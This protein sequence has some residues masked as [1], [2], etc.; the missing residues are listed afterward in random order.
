MKRKLED[1]KVGNLVYKECYTSMG[2]SS[3][4]KTIVEE[5]DN[6]WDVNTGEKFVI[7]KV[8]DEWYDTRNGSCFSNPNSMFYIESI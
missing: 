7:L 8:D 6:K 5:I 4:G 3:T 2:A 1:S